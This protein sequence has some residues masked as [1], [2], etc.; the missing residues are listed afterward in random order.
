M[1]IE[2]MTLYQ[3]RSRKTKHAVLTRQIQQPITAKI[4]IMQ[5]SNVEALRPAICAPY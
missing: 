2:G 1:H 5:L 4:F 3:G